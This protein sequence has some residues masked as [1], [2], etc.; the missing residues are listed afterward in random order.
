MPFNSI[1]FAIFFPLFFICYWLTSHRY[2][3]QNAIILIASYIFY[4]WWD[5]RF[6]LLILLSTLVDFGVGHQLEDEKS[7]KRKKWLLMISL[8][9]NLGMLGFFKYYNFFVDSFISGFSILGLNLSNSHLDIILP[10]GISFYTFQTMSYTLD[11]YKGKFHATK[12]FVGFAAFVSFFPQLVAGPIERASHLLPQFL[13]T[14]HF[15]YA[16][17]TDGLRQI[18]WGLFKK[19]VIAN[20]CA[21][22]VDLI[23]TNPDEHSSTSLVL[24][25]I[26]FTIQIYCDFSGYSDMAIGISK[27]LGIRLSKNFAFP[28]FSRDIAEFWRRWHISLSTWFRDYLY[29][30]LGGSRGNLRIKIRNIFIVFIISGFWH[31]ANFTFIIWG[32]L[33]AFYFL[34]LMIWQKNR[35]HTDTVA[36]GKVLPT[37]KEFFQM[38]GTFILT[39]LA[40]IFFRAE[41][42]ENAYQYFIRMSDFTSTIAFHISDFKNV[43]VIII[44][45]I[46]LFSIEWLGREKKH[47]LETMFS[48][49]R[50][51]FRWSFYSLI[52]FLIGMFMETNETPFIYF[53]F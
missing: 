49:N 22:Y 4:G 2:K 53:Q 3:L 40:F 17:A 23:F 34:P 28:F 27:L 8:S 25:A 35:I 1:D 14:R 44:L 32:A 7:T 50:R 42:T 48:I 45:C 15:N 36:A 9:A 39:V 11:I 47:A 21:S 19:M 51:V 31:G 29:I 24:G 16:S 37:I 10:V 30:P 41:N 18:L 6:L 33:N 26:F 38:V 20:N 46:F 5:W 52:L 43:V 12:D 13:K